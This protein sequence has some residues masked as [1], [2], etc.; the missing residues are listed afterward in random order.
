MA[1]AT[2]EPGGTKDA[3]P[4]PRDGTHT[5]GNGQSA[6]K[7]NFSGECTKLQNTAATAGPGRLRTHR[8]GNRAEGESTG[9]ETHTKPE[10][11]TNKH[12]QTSTAPG[13][14]PAGGLSTDR[15]VHRGH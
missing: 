15:K 6:A 13:K 12:K 5:V 3:G 14:A 7:E 9:I 11:Q 1:E 10:K 2:A 8:D 4:K